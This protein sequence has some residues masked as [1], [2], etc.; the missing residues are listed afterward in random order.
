[1]YKKYK[2]NNKLISQLPTKQNVQLGIILDVDDRNKSFGIKF[3]YK[4]KI[5]HNC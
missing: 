2:K 4:Q 3:I 1:M 5:T